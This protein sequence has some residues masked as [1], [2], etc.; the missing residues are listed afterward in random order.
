MTNNATGDTDALRTEIEQTRAE[1]GDTA[2]A[3][4]A[5]ADVKARA[6]QSATRRTAAVK[7]KAVDVGATAGEKAGK[8]V[9][10]VADAAGQVRE[11]VTAVDVPAA[12]RKPAPLAGIA[13]AAVAL[14]T[15]AVLLIRRS[16]R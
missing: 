12:V 15:G 8:A 7:A 16:R 2:A 6:R 11:R 13:V 3:L 14:I 4:V 1:L 5:K 9:Q 10:Q